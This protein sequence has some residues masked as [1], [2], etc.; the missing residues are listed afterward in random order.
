MEAV[1]ADVR[2]NVT[3]RALALAAIRFTCSDN[4]RL[5]GA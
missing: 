3:A 5:S 4:A 2:Q 1:I